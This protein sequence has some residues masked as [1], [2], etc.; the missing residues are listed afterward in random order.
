M[1][2]MKTIKNMKIIELRDRRETYGH[3]SRAINRHSLRVYRVIGVNPPATIASSEFH[4][5]RTLDG[6]PPFYELYF[7]KPMSAMPTYLNVKGQRYWGDGLSWAKAEQHA[8]KA[9]KDFMDL[10]EAKR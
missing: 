8:F 7:Y 9:I 1:K 3:D 10:L 2:T 6:V 4:L 5:N